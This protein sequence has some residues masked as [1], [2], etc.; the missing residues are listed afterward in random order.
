MTI[1]IGEHTSGADDCVAEFAEIF[2][3]FVLV[4]EAE[5][6]AGA[7]YLTHLGWVTTTHGIE[8]YCWSF[9]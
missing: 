3:F 4:L 9:V 6:F 2:D 5:D 1:M 8:A 7:R